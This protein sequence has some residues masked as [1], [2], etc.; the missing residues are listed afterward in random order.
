LSIFKTQTELIPVELVARHRWRYLIT[1][2][3]LLLFIGFIYGWSIL[4]VPLQGA[5]GWSASDMAVTFSLSMALFCVGGVVGSQITARTTPQL[6]ILVAAVLVCA[7]YLI[8]SRVDAA[9]IIVLHSAYG[10]LVGGCSGMAHNAIMGSVNR[11]FPDRVGTSSGFLTL[12]MGLGNL[13]MS[14]FV[15]FAIEQFGWRPAFVVTGVVTALALAVG[16]FL[17]R[18]PASDQRFPDPKGQVK[19]STSISGDDF[20]TREM[21]RL[22]PFYLTFA[23][24]VLLASVYLGIMGNAKQI[25]LEAGAL[26]TLATFMVG[27][28][29]LFDAAGRLGSGLFFDRFGYRRS[30][31]AVAALFVASATMLFVSFSVGQLV[32]VLVGFVFLGLS[33][34]SISTVL[35]A[36][37][38][39]FYGQRHYGSNLSVAYCD[40]VPASVIG[41]PLAGLIQTG[42]GSYHLVFAALLVPAVIA[43]ALSFLIKPPQ[44]KGR[45]VGF[46][47][48]THGSQSGNQSAQL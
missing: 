9:D 28:I 1:G 2:L 14:M 30:L 47:G 5:F 7:G 31:I 12:G 10:A 13:A 32:L 19:T 15:G 17:I 26:M 45:G 4:A 37:T 20:S 48:G 29:S 22:P 6:T 34:G 46:K 40:F 44:K 21:L 11:W 27:L 16:S 24:A 36:V 18:L 39:R 38:N 25:A 42:T 8:A 23:W 41:P 33:F 43:L 3:V 35:A